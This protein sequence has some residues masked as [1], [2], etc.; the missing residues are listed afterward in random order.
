MRKQSLVNM[1]FIMILLLLIG[2]SFNDGLLQ[3]NNNSAGTRGIINKADSL[4]IAQNKP[5]T[6][7]EWSGLVKSV[8][9]NTSASLHDSG[10]RYRQQHRFNGAVMVAKDGVPVYEE[11]TGF[12]DMGKKTPFDDS[13]R[14]QLAS[15]SKQFT[16]VAVLM[17]QQ[18]G[19]LHIDS[20]LT[21]Y[22][23][24]LPYEGV[25]L[26]HLLH[27]EAGFPGYM[28]L[29]AR[30]WNEHTA[31]D[32]Q[33][34]VKMM[35]E[36]PVKLR[37]TPGSRFQYSNTGYSLL[38]AVAERV[39]GKDFDVFM[40]EA[41]F[42]PLNMEQ[43]FA[44]SAA[45]DTLHPDMVR[46]FR[47]YNGKYHKVPE[48]LMEGTYGDKNIYSTPRDLLKWAEG[49]YSGKLLNKELLDI[50]LAPSD[51]SSSKTVNYGMGFRIYDTHPGKMVYHNG[52]W[53]G[54]RTTLRI[55]PEKDLTVIVLTNNSFR[56]TGEMARSLTS[57]ITNDYDANTVYDLASSFV[58]NKPAD[59]YA[60]LNQKDIDD[61][62]SLQSIMTNMD[63][64]WMAHRIGT[65]ADEMN[66]HS[67]EWLAMNKD[68]RR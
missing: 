18:Q 5:L 36:H 63:R 58:R 42:Q 35:A 22:L 14:F 43:S 47:Y 4:F 49:L 27:H 10:E 30:H 56:K 2:W 32:N 61:L 23:P 6:S 21:T 65:F 40:Q 17:L 34:V 54:F 53:S 12:A 44:Y 25:T 19:K 52:S 13:S 50:A 60:M 64:N 3:S 11:Y 68:I 62:R 9:R 15:V 20:T 38:A 66:V 26:R 67:Y 33:D 16:A 48:N 51:G 55:I 39:S 45:K 8:Y 28:W 57:T 41:V 59:E 46:G 37:F 7:E 29:I 1:R 24:E 31:P